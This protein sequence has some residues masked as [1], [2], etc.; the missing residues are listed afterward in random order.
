MTTATLLSYYHLCH[1]KL[2][3]HARQIQME[4][5]TNNQYV[6][7][8]KLLDE[9]SYA[10]RPQKWRELNLGFVKI[11]H[12]DPSTHTVKEIKRSPK[13][14]H[15]HV[16]QVQYYLWVLE[17]RGIS[18]QK[19]IIEYPRQRKSTEVVL[20]EEVRK[21]IEGWLAEI[22]RISTQ[23]QCPPLVKKSYCKKCAFYDFCYV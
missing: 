6:E 15:A 14:E 12:F 1:R 17:Q 3:L 9:T 22:E 5:A 20:T 16:A 10:R 18:A 13:L 23:E 11:D 4:N 8:G 2:W 7:E 19:G 21:E